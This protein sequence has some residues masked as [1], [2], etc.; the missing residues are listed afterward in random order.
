MGIVLEIKLRELKH[1]KNRIL[2]EVKDTE[3]YKV[4]EEILRKYD[5]EYR[6][7]QQP[8][9]A[10]GEQ[11]QQ[12]RHRRRPADQNPSGARPL[13]QQLAPAPTQAPAPAPALAMVQHSA[14]AS[15]SAQ[16]QPQVYQ[17]MPGYVARP[18]PGP[19]VPC[20]IL[21]RERS[22][23]DKIVEYLIGDGPNNRFALICKHCHSHNGMAL[24]DEY[25]YLSKTV[26]RHIS[27]AIVED[28]VTLWFSL[29][30]CLL[31]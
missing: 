21:P 12:L 28:D 13:P 22:T 18:A 17:L 29:S 20:P 25:E 19:P 1:K 8:Q 10:S 31:L 7:R 27:T 15:S 5:T 30:L 6:R 3:T 26:K 11:S 16:Q 9:P 4:A 24:P 14:P 23:T 2:D